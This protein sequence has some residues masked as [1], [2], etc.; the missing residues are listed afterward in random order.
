MNDSERFDLM[1]DEIYELKKENKRLSDELQRCTSGNGTYI[2]I[3]SHNREVKRLTE[4]NEQLTKRLGAAVED[5]REH[6]D[7]KCYVCVHR[8]NGRCMI[9]ERNCAGFYR[10]Q[11]RGPAEQEEN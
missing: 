4:E 8:V 5:L 6:A 2:S 1:L 7:R 9:P 11:W 3:E 10:W